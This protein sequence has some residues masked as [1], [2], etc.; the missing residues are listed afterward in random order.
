M[1]GKQKPRKGSLA[2][3]P[4]K[5]SK[6]QNP[7]L[8]WPKKED[9][10]VLGFA[11]Y[12]AGMTHVSYVDQSESPTKGKEI[13]SAATVLEVP[14]LVVYG[15]RGYKK[16]GSAGDILCDDEKILKSAGIKKGKSKK[17][18]NADELSDVRL[19]VAMQPSKTGFGKKHPEKC[20]I[21]CGGEDISGKLEYAKGLIGKELKFSEVFKPGEYVDV[22]AVTKGK[23]WQG[24][25]KR[26]G[27]KI[28]RRKATGK[29]RHVGTLGAFHPAYIIYTVPQ[30]GQMGYHRRTE[31]NKLILHSGEKTE[32][33]NPISGFPKYGKLKNDYV[34]IK[35]SIAG[36]AKRLVKLRLAMRKDTPAPEQPVKY[37]SLDP[38]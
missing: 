36:P 25:V 35:G 17:E 34:I 4:R 16:G 18:L 31:I 13:V 10:R 5:R 9:K 2:L 1:S 30:A 6:T 29:R 20:E 28:Q 21:G 33:V 11:G 38:R 3:W 8:Y 37:I 12:K 32:E 15:I 27:I 23:G 14:P 7:S 22:T 19:L 24:P 26:F